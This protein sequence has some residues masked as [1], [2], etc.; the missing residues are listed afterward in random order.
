MVFVQ[1]SFFMMDL[2]HN[3][4]GSLRGPKDFPE[5]KLFLR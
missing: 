4:Y 3:E 2:L 5:G 1:R